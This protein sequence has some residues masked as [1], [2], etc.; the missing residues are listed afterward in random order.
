MQPFG[1]DPNTESNPSVLC[2]RGC[3][4]FSVGL[5]LLGGSKAAPV[6]FYAAA[7]CGWIACHEVNK[8]VACTKRALGLQI[9]GGVIVLHQPCGLIVSLAAAVKN[10]CH[11]TTAN[12]E[13]EDDTER[14]CNIARGWN[15]GSGCAPPTQ[16]GNENGAGKQQERYGDD[17]PR[18][19]AHGP[20][21]LAY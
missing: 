6:Q 7:G 1:I 2:I 21:R 14:E 17:R 12:G 4:L 18:T 3:K 5:K 19:L 10:Q 9:R 13:R 20:C 16:I 8:P 15:V 11:Q